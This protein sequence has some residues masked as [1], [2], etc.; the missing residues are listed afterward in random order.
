MSEEECRRFLTAPVRPAMLGTVRAD[1]RPH[2][3]PVW[4]DLDDDGALVFTTGANTVK[5]TALRRDPRACLCVDDDRPPFAY[6]LVE[7]AAE[8]SEDPAS[9]L[10]WAT[11]LGG[12][13]MGADRAEEYGRRNGV[14]GEL[15]VRV[16]PAKVVGWTGVAD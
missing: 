2:T 7:G 10:D 16:V 4:Y 1:G 12:R 6:V 11:R 15:L 8:L 3:A 14:P 9:L 13:Y 5:G